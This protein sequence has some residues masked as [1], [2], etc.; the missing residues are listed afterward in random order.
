MRLVYAAV[1]CIVVAC[2]T[3]YLRAEASATAFPDRGVGAA[4]FRHAPNLGRLA[5]LPDPFEPAKASETAIRVAQVGSATAPVEETSGNPAQ[6]PFKWAGLLTEPHPTK[7]HPNQ[8]TSCTAQF[9]APRLLLTAGHCINDLPP[10]PS[11]PPSDPTTWTFLLQYQ[12]GG[13]G[14]FKV[15]CARA[16]PLWALPPN[17]DSLTDDQK[18]AAMDAAYQ[19]DF[20]MILVDRDSTTGVMPYALD[21]KGKVTYASRIGYPENIL[22][23]QIIQS[24]PGIVFFTDVLPMNIPRYGQPAMSSPNIVAQWG[25]IT[26]ATQGMSGGAWVY[27]LDPAERANSNILIAVTSFS[28]FNGYKQPF[29]P[30]G[31]FAAYLTAA[32]FNPLFT[33]VSNGCK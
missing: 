24:V 30:G 12:N 32:E 26:D 6:A 15:V 25:P 1:A 27:N 3:R 16:N 28:P 4:G 33:F 18:N 22:D 19:H 14:V 10:D 7:E 29:Y 23:A 13:G 5:G 8:S 21:W 17:F 31:T 11:V 2:G 9:I 20:G